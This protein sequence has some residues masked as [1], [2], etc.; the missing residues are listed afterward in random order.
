LSIAR[1]DLLIAFLGLLAIEL[2]VAAFVYLVAGRLGAGAT[3][4]LVG[5]VLVLFFAL[6][7]VGPLL[8][9]PESI[10]S[11]SLFHQYGT[12]LTTA[13]RWSAWAAM[14]GI[15]VVFLLVGLARF[16]RGDVQRGN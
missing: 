2:P 7:L 13:P 16:E 9:W 6:G 11:L 3:L 10:L 5:G 12:P 14:V 4:G 1:D 8:G 15:A